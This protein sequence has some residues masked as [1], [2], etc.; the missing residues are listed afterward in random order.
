MYGT[1]FSL[2]FWIVFVL[3]RLFGVDEAVVSRLKCVVVIKH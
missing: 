3:L 1:P 2:T